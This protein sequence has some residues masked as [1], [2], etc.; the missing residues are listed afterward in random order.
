MHY[1]YDFHG[2]KR[3]ILAAE[4][5]PLFCVAV[6][7]EVFELLRQAPPDRLADLHEAVAALVREQVTRWQQRE[8]AS[9]AGVGEASGQ[10]SSE[11]AGDL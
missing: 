1:V 2:R 10:A 7:G 6:D 3:L 5:R 11:R 4:A 8:E 9:D